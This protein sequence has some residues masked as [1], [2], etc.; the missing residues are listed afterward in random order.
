LDN[1]AGSATI[2]PAEEHMGNIGYEKLACGKKYE[3]T[4]KMGWLSCLT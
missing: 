1:R 2:Q 4:G 3:K